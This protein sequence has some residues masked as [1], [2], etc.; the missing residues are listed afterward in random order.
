MT[1]HLLCSVSSS[2]AEEE[3]VGLTGGGDVWESCLGAV[4]VANSET[5]IQIQRGGWR[6]VC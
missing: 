6:G 4:A 1:V 5:N 3:G 2:E